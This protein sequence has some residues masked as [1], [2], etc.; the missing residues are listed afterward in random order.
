MAKKNTEQNKQDRVLRELKRLEG[1]FEDITD[2]NKREFV[3]RQIEE[4]AW[5]VVSASDLQREIDEKGH[6]VPFQNGRNQNGLQQN[7][8][9]KILNDYMKQI[10]TI[11]RTLLP[12]VP[13]KQTRDELDDFLNGDYDSEYWEK[14]KREDEERQKK[15]QAEIDR[16]IE[17]Q[18][19]ERE[20]REKE[21]IS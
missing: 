20:Q 18:R 2:I 13:E 16:A 8:G 7:P 11:T 12:V 21:R 17:Q 6:V 10:N 9:V 4:L 3:Q 5:L 15:I 14:R 1:I 19:R